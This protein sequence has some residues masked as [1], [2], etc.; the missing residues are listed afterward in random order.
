MKVNTNRQ[1]CHHSPLCS[2]RGHS[3]NGIAVLQ[4]W[5][6]SHTLYS[7]NQLWLQKLSLRPIPQHT[8]QGWGYLGGVGGVINFIVE[9]QPAWLRP[10]SDLV[11]GCVLSD[12]ITSGQGC[13]ADERSPVCSPEERSEDPPI[14]AGHQMSRRTLMWPRDTFAYTLLKEFGPTPLSAFTTCT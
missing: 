1:T 4:V 14:P 12:R 3:L 7:A 13:E 8:K 9:Q 5:A 11:L 2:C 10:S 6:A